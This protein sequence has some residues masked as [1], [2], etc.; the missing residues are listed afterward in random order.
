MDVLDA[1]V[2]AIS[3]A[4]MLIVGGTSLIVYPAAG[5]LR[6]FN[7]D[8]LVLINKTATQADRKATLV[9]HDSLGKVFREAVA[10]LTGS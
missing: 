3:A 10:G 8:R 2:R 1:A 6:Y 4:D 9:I 7:G 5:L